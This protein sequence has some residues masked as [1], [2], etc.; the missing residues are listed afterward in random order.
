MLFKDRR[1]DLSAVHSTGYI[2]ACTTN[3]KQFDR[4]VMCCGGAVIN[5]SR[6]AAFGQAIV[7]PHTNVSV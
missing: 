7:R 1:V 6:V 3:Q 4:V 5:D 2:V